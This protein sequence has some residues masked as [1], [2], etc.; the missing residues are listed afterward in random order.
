MDNLLHVASV[1]GDYHGTECVKEDYNFSR[2]S[3]FVYF[4]SIR[5]PHFQKLLILL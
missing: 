4:K 3:D 5:F 2:I 1:I